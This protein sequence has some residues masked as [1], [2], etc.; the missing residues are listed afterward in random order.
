MKRLMLATLLI[1]AMLLPGC[2][3]MTD[4]EKTVAGGAALGAGVGTALGALIGGG[5]G[6]AIGAAVGGATGLLVGSVIAERKSQY[7]SREDFLAAEIKRVAEYNETTSAYN[8]QLRVNIARLEEEVDYL[9]DEHAQEEVRHEM[10]IAKRAEL[11]QQLHFNAELEQDLA[12]ELEVLMA[13]LDQE[14]DSESDD[15]LQISQ[16]ENEILALQDNLELLREGSV[17]LAGIDERL[18]L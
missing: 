16:L 2:A 14:R 7:A 3:T 1:I 13:I 15:N 18:Q 12:N 6:A 17:Q 11:T 4:K 9:K 10:L 8:Q 5:R